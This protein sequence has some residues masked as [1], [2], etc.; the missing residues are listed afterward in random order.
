MV[1]QKSGFAEHIQ[2]DNSIMSPILRCEEMIMII[3]SYNI[4]T[5]AF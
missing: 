3:A 5:G 4:G 2:Q 1:V